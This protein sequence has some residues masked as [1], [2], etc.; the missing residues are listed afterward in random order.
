MIPLNK[1]K[2]HIDIYGKSW[3]MI[4]T[5][6]SKTIDGDCCESDRRIRISRDLRGSDLTHTV[7]HELVHAILYELG[8]RNTTLHPDTNEIISDGV[9]KALTEICEIKL[10]D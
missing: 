6:V 1:K 4:R 2:F 3:T 7:L 5:R 9:A 8:F 10:K